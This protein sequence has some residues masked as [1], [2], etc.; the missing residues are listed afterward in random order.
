MQTDRP[1][2]A[3]RHIEEAL[4]EM[5]IHAIVE[6]IVEKQEDE[7]HRARFHSSSD[8]WRFVE[9]RASLVL[10]YLYPLQD[11]LKR[12]PTFQ[13]WQKGARPEGLSND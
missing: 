9:C 2:R 11:Q 8:D 4:A 13:Q 12:F 10:A 5:P 6:A 3:D 1:H 7:K